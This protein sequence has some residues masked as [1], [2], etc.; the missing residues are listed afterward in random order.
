[1]LYLPQGI[2]A[3][4]ALRQE[5]IAV[6]EYPL[7]EKVIAAKCR[8]LLLNLM[9]QKAVTELDLARMMGLSGI[10]VQLVFLKI[11]GQTYKN[12]PAAHMDAF[13]L[14]FEG[15]QG[16]T[17]D[18]LVVTGAPVEQIPFEE[19]RY[20]P[21]LCHIMDWAYVSVKSTLYICWGAQAGLYHFYGVEKHALAEK[22]FG[23]FPQ[24]V[25][26]AGCPILQG[27]EPQFVM[28]N[29]RHT[30]VW[31]DE[32]ARKAGPKGAHVVAES[33]ESGVGIVCTDD[34]RLIFIVGHLEYEPFTL[35]NEYK[36]DLSRNLPIHAPEH[37]YAPD[38]KVLYSWKTD[39]QRFYANY[40]AIISDNLR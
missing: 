37:Y 22:R 16:G 35:D 25:T 8:L 38:G 28:P 32:I 2:P 14:D 4:T 19:V 13:Y 40:L 15:V 33:E 7:G 18:G 1:M 34:S 30:E 31:K 24:R 9:P 5:G 10:D 3:A 27:M 23:I 26:K 39:A 36:R 20:W 29:S 6:S 21:Q 17:W 12:T 11:K